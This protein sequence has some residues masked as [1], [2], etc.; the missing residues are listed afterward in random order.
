M[1]LS[2]GD[3]Y[4]GGTDELGTLSI[5]G[6]YTQGQIFPQSSY[7][8]LNIELESATSYDRLSVNGN[9]TLDGKLNVSIIDDLALRPFVHRSEIR[10]TSWTGRA[11]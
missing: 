3:I 2:Y 6:N 4:P 9:I 8:T 10:S 1:S 11:A 5:S 7:G